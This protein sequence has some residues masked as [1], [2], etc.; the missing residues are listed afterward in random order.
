MAQKARIEEYSDGNVTIYNLRN[1]IGVPVFGLNEMISASRVTQYWDGTPMDDSKVDNQL[2]LQLKSLPDDSNTELEKYVGDYFKVNL[3][4]EGELF[5]EKDTMQEMRDVNSTEILLLQMGYYKGVKLNGYYAKGD[6][7][8]SIEYR[9]STTSDADD[10]GSVIEV[11]GVKLEHDFKDGVINSTYFGSIADKLT[12]NTEIIQK[13]LNKADGGGSL[14]IPRDTLFDIHQLVIPDNISINY[15][16]S[17]KTYEQVIFINKIHRNGTPVN[18]VEYSSP[19]HTGLVLNVEEDINSNIPPDASTRLARSLVYRKNGRTQLINTVLGDGTYLVRHVRDFE[20]QP[21]GEHVYS[22]DGASSDLIF[23]QNIRTATRKGS[24][25]AHSR[26]IVSMADI[27]A[28]NYFVD[29]V[30]GDDTNQGTTASPFKTVEKALDQIAYLN[31]VTANIR[32]RGHYSS[33]INIE[34][35]VGLKSSVTIIGDSSNRSENILSS[36]VNIRNCIGGLLFRNFEVRS[37]LSITNS[38]NVIAQDIIY[39]PESGG[40]F[41]TNS[42]QVKI[43]SSVFNGQTY[44]IRAS[45]S[46]V[47]SENNS[48][49]SVNSLR[50]MGASIIYQKGTQASGVMQENTGGTIFPKT[51]I[52]LATQ[53]EVNTG[54]N[55][56]KAVTPLT[57]QNKVA[58]TTVKG[59]VNQATASADSASPVGETYSQSEVQA[60]L[61]EL[62]DLKAKM[63]TAGML[64]S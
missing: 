33:D 30:N 21:F 59:L 17:E 25:F 41:I 26:P 45:D 46:Y 9:L 44:G 28:F 13:A 18:E 43:S 12:D 24:I 48:G 49:S 51:Y 10:G 60:I 20:A 32:I 1:N 55:D 36:T 22:I 50:S 39:S 8:A 56:T 4:N 35:L 14:H 15:F 53:S 7:P 63:R 62:R 34:G 58:T 57:L 2:Y 61:N 5:L 54:T 19:Y 29:E 38:F 31:L 11:G 42:S 23:A 3:P 47:I 40:V 6:T 64:N 52:T 27:L 16:E 37:L